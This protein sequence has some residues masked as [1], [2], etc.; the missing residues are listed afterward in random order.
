[1]RS[2]AAGDGAALGFGSVGLAGRR[3]G[4]MLPGLQPVR[5]LRGPSL[6]TPRPFGRGVRNP[7]ANKCCGLEDRLTPSPQIE[8][9]DEKAGQNPVSIL[10]GR[11][12]GSVLRRA[13]VRTS[14]MLV[15]GRTATR[16]GDGRHPEVRKQCGWYIRCVVYM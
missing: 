15:E 7:V 14:V 6:S 12:A 1:M 3:E 13:Q 16:A 8:P 11:G 9:M 2:P 4:P 5:P 10:A